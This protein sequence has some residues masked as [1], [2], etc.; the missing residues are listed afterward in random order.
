MSDQPQEAD[1]PEQA[2]PSASKAQQQLSLPLSL[3][4]MALAFGIGMGVGHFSASAAE[5][6][7]SEAQSAEIPKGD[8]SLIYKIPVSPSQPSKGPEEALVTVVQWCDF[9]DPACK[10]TDPV[11]QKLLKRYPNELRL[12]FRHYVSATRK[13][14]ALAHQFARAAFERGKFW[15]AHELLLAHQGEVTHAALEG[16][17]STLGLDWSALKKALD[18]GTFSGHLAAD[19][20]FA[21]MFD[22]KA[23]G[24]LYVNGR[25]VAGTE[26][27]LD[28]LVK[29]ELARANKLL[30]GGVQKTEL[31]AELTKHGTWKPAPRPTPAQ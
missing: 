18:A 16:Y 21:E 10:Q 15:E 6:G 25:P 13:D 23:S 24:A 11:L 9:P 26:A 4:A 2:P 12:V 20:M 28:A 27:A 7:S 19:R 17:A 22:V 14:S 31:Y 29:E 8:S 1:K 3:G 5:R 30:A